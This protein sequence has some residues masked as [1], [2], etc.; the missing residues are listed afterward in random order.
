MKAAD[1]SARDLLG[2]AALGVL[3]LPGLAVGAAAGWLTGLLGGMLAGGL[4]AALAGAGEAG[5]RVVVEV[6]GGLGGGLG[7]LAGLATIGAVF[8][9]FHDGEGAA[10]RVASVV[11]LTLLAAGGTALSPLVATDAP[12][13]VLSAAAATA[14]VAGAALLGPR[15]PW[16]AV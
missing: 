15:P 6:G 13:A 2:G 7:A 9:A 8:A 1:R 11:G 3:L 16:T 5:G 14:A 10:R 12:Q 4:A